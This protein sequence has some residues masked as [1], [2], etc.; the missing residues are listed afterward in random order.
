[1]QLHKAEGKLSKQQI[2]AILEKITEEI[3]SVAYMYERAYH[4]SSLYV[5][6]ALQDGLVP[7]SKLSLKSVRAVA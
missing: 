4:R 5:L 3:S 1:L 6:R 2:E 7:R